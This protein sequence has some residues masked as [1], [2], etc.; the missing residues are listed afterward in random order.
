MYLEKSGNPAATA[1]GTTLWPL[2]YDFSV[3]HY[4]N[5]S[6]LS[7]VTPFL[8]IVWANHFFLLILNHESN[9]YWAILNYST[10]IF[11][12]K[13]LTPCDRCYDFLNIFAEKFSKNI[14]IFYSKQS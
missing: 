8:N 6:K 4:V 14:G 13:N 10:A 5:D 12:L 1:H 7:A 2:C 11:F 3:V 9:A